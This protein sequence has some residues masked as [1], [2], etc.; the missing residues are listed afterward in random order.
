MT[1]TVAPAPGDTARLLPPSSRQRRLAVAL[2]LVALV[3]VAVV[4]VTRA[5]RHWVPIGDLALVDLRV[6]DVWSRAIPLVGTYNRFGWNHP[7]PAMFWLLA[8]L[9]GLTGRPAWATLIGGALI[10]GAAIAVIAWLAWRKGGVAL[11]AAALALSGLAYGAFGTALV[12]WPWN[13]SIAFPWFLVLVLLAWSLA[14]GELRLLPFLVAVATFVVQTHV[15]YAPLAVATVG[16]AVAWAAVGRRGPDGPDAVASS[17]ATPWRGPLLWSALVLAVGW[18]PVA[19]QELIRRPNIERLA[20][21]LLHSP[22]YPRLGLDFAAGVMADAFKVPPLWLGGHTTLDKFANTVVPASQWWLLV[23]VALLV[24]AGVSVMRP[25]GRRFRALVVLSALLILVGIWAVARVAGPAERY[26]FYWRVPLAL[27]LVFA[28][29]GSAWYA[30]GL[31][32]SVVARRCAFVGLSAIVVFS[33]TA[34]SV[35]I[36]QT[37]DILSAESLARDALDRLHA[38]DQP[39]GS[40]LVR[41]PDTAYYGLERAVVNELDRGGHEVK[42]DG[43]AGFQFGESRTAT[44][45][46][47]D[48]VMYVVEGGQY[49]SV[50]SG[51]PGARVLWSTNALP[52]A[53][54][55]EL[56]RLQQQLWEE[57][58]AAGRPDLFTALS[59]PIVALALARVPSVDQRAAQRVAELNAEA[60]KH[61]PCRCGIVVFSSADAPTAPLPH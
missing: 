38:E 53:R 32:A 37:G 59:S 46:Q 4:V 21:F 34:L 9:S 7:G 22:G 20:D 55:Q 28:A 33:S 5:G 23:P 51:E 42:V 29:I 35:R 17:M 13:P 12:L 43:D 19:L 14:D 60:A 10:Q 2:T 31:D 41:A 49:L 57:L 15:G 25:A 50:L 56:R 47:V 30:F 44:P 54:E 48:Q 24:L 18:A 36:V 52:P 26:V 1:T 61:A 16:F 8:P 45:S 39:S 27:I 3:P 11:V 40:V 58:R 6:R